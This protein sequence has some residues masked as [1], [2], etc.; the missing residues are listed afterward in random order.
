MI[1]RLVGHRAEDAE[2]PALRL[3][4]RPADMGAVATAVTGRMGGDPANWQ[5][6]RRCDDIS[7][8]VAA[9][10]ARQ[11]TSHTSGQIAEALGYRNPSSISV[12]CRRVE[13]SIKR[14]ESFARQAQ[15]IIADLH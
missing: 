10:V 8:A 15:A 1:R 5:P 14:N 6:G 11:A 9:Y 12:A 2:V 13:Q 3:L 7:R 4:K